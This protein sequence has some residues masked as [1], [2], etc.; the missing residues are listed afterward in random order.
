MDD[1]E[2]DEEDEE[3]SS[4]K[5]EGERRDHTLHYEQVFGNISNKRESKCCAVLVKHPRKVNGKQLSNH[6]P[7]SSKTKN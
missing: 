7:I 5:R 4:I 2:R 6:S 3:S 1:F